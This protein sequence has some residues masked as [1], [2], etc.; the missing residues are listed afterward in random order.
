MVAFAIPVALAG[1]MP[2]FPSQ[3]LVGLVPLSVGAGVLLWCT[4]EFYV[5]GQG[6]LA[7]WAPPRHLVVTGPYRYSRNPMYVGV[8]LILLGWAA[9]YWSR[10][11]LIYAGCVVVAFHLRVVLAE[12]PWA[13]RTFGDAWNAYRERTP[14]WLA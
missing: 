14:R 13:A 7:P 11:L 6:T 4:R 5:A 2:P 12:E 10:L 9:L 1:R 8:A 3:H